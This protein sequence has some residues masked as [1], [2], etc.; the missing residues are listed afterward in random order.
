MENYTVAMKTFC[1]RIGK[2]DDPV[3]FIKNQLSRGAITKEQL[4]RIFAD[5]HNLVDYMHVGQC[6]IGRAHV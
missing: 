6:E 4:L 1:Q 3:A 2:A 5:D